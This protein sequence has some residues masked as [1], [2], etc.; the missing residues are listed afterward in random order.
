MG[1]LKLTGYISKKN[2]LNISFFL[3]LLGSAWV[4]DRYHTPEFGFE[5]E[6]EQTEQADHAVLYFCNPTGNLSLKAPIQKILIKKS[7][8]SDVDRLLRLHHSSRAFHILKAEKPDI[9]EKISFRNLLAFRNY[10]YTTPDD[11]PPSL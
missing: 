3:V 6:E 11:Q 5:V 4:F 10:H 9:P 2:I 1:N 8:Y 7:L